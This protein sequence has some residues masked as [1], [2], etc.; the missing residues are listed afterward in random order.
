[1][2]SL[3]SHWMPF[4]IGARNENDNWLPERF[5]FRTVAS[6][7]PTLRALCVA[8]RQDYLTQLRTFE[9]AVEQNAKR[10]NIEGVTVGFN[11][12]TL[13]FVNYHKHICRR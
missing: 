2:Q 4:A 13:S 3:R 8:A 12:L 6:G 10:K 1:M 5:C 11:Q 9:F 7:C